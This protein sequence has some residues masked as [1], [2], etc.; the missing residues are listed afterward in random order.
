M[1]NYKLQDEQKQIFEDLMK[2][3]RQVKEDLKQAEKH[4]RLQPLPVHRRESSSI[5]YRGKLPGVNTVTRERNRIKKKIKIPTH[6]G[7]NYA[8]L[9]IGP[10]GSN[11][12]RL[13]E[14]TGCKILIR[15]RGSQ[16]EGQAPQSDDFDDL[17][18]QVAG[19]SEQQVGR[20]VQEIERI[21]FADERTRNNLR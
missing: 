15:G 9:I 2:N 18:V 11:Q 3:A 14:K 12:K 8:G 6:N 4:G 7:F 1:Q 13:E 21:I 5:Y 20:A 19:D 17:H 16:K 10:K